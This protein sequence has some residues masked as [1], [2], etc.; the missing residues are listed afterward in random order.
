MRNCQ[1]TPLCLPFVFSD[2]A[3]ISCCSLAKSP[4]RRSLKHWLVRQLSSHSATFNQLPCLGVAE[5]KAFHVRAGCRRCECFVERAFA[6]R[7][8]VVAYQG[9]TFAIHVTRVQ[10]LAPG[11]A[12]TAGV[13]VRVVEVTGRT[14]APH[15]QPV[16][17]LGLTCRRRARR[18][19]TPTT[20]RAL[21]SPRNSSFG[22]PRT[23]NSLSTTRPVNRPRAF[24]LS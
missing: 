8:Q 1:S 15:V 14:V 9:H 18:I 7:V 10:A 12:A 13:A 23:Q 4:M 6:V 21:R 3:A 11:A 19:R 22:C 2:H 24:V 17:P 20:T 5:L 16:I